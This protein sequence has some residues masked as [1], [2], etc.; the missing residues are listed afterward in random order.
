MIVKEKAKAKLKS[1]LGIAR[2]SGSIMAGVDME[3]KLER[4][5]KKMFC[6]PMFSSQGGFYLFFFIC[7]HLREAEQREKFRRKREAMKARQKKKKVRYLSVEKTH[8]CCFTVN[9]F[10][11]CVSCDKG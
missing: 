6:F 7:F 4:E 2:M 5:A 8:F 3:E 11:I 1:G 9:T 10:L